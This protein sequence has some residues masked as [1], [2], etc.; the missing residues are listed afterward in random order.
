MLTPE[1][2]IATSHRV[3]SKAIGGDPVAK[4]E[5]D[6]HAAYVKL[7]FVKM[8]FSYVHYLCYVSSVL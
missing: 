5:L 1:I 4:I 8:Q 3:N 6:M 7:L 2:K